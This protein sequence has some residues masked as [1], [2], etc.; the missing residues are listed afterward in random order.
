MPLID[1]PLVE[2]ICWDRDRIGKDYMGEFDIAVDDIFANGK[3]NQEVCD[4]ARPFLACL[5]IDLSQPK[6][7][8]LKSRR[9]ESKKSSEVSGEVLMQFSLYDAGN[10]AAS[11]EEI[12][13]KFKSTIQVDD[14]DFDD[15]LARLP[16]DDTN[17]D[18]DSDAGMDEAGK[19]EETSDE[20][21]DQTKPELSEKKRKRKKLKMLRRKSRAIRA[22]EFTGKNS[23]VSGIIFLEIGKI[24]DLPPE[25]NSKFPNPINVPCG[26]RIHQ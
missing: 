12:Y 22:Y 13:Y 4:A 1:V 2:C 15:H 24:T 16:R 3:L 5:C 18:E 25:K 6:W 9:R 14:G 21:E 8:T 23:D 20:T 19:D 10:P 11:P 17:A 7:Y 26:L